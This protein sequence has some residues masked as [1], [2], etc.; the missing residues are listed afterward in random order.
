[1]T[2]DKHAADLVSPLSSP[3]DAALHSAIMA[4]I[5][6]GI[7][8]FDAATKRIREAN[9]ALCG[10]LGYTAAELLG[11][12]L[13]DIVAHDRASVD[14]NIARIVAEGRNAIGDRRY[15]R[16]DGTLV[17]VEV[18]AVA[19]ATTGDTTLC[20]VVRDTTERS[21]AEAAIRA[22]EAR[23]RLVVANHPFILFALDR[24]GTIT[25]AAG[26]GLAALGLTPEAVVGR[27]IFTISRSPAV[28]GYVRRAL[29]GESFDAE[30]ILGERHF[31]THYAP[32]RDTDGA[33]AGAI[34]VALDVT[35]Q[36]AAEASVRRFAAGLSE[37]ERAVLPLLA[38]ER[39]PNYRA[40]GVRLH[41]E[42]D[43]VRTHL[44]HI[45]LKLGCAENRAA[46]VAAARERGLLG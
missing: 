16:K 42:R 31:A 15:R 22:S 28:P 10:L 26:R 9:P 17:T 39:L 33:I 3:G 5:A 38:D 1:M 34:G 23:L 7:V 6:E 37:R 20:A 21:R 4:Q 30:V 41:I 13:Y 36:R 32:L 8:V 35:V 24:D 14:A 18:G 27:S 29:A 43:T 2:A 25:L 46:V 40:I 19:L 12:T 11:L 45:A 44:K